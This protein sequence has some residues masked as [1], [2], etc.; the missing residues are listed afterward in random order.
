MLSALTIAGLVLLTS[1]ASSQ[2]GTDHVLNP[3][4]LI[5]PADM[6][7]KESKYYNTLTDPEAAKSFIITRSYVRLCQKV[8][9]KTMPAEQLPDKPLGF[10]ARYLLSGEATLINTAI[11]ESITAEMR[12]KKPR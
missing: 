8:I 4:Q 12:A 10:A 7:P 5:T 9:D 6:T 11:A 1:N 2:A 3:S